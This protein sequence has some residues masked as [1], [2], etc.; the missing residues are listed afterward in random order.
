M[1]KCLV[2][3][4]ELEVLGNLDDFTK[5]VRCLCCGFENLPKREVLIIK[6]SR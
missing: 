4:G 5:K 3:G 6:K 2:C 1:L